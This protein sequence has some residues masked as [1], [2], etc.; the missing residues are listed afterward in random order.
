MEKCG[1]GTTNE[2]FATAT[3]FQMH[4]C[5]SSAIYERRTWTKHRPLFHNS[6]CMEPSNFKIYLY[7]TDSQDHYDF[8]IPQL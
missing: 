5:I 6:T 4:I 3:L 7:H 8:V 2:I 1:W